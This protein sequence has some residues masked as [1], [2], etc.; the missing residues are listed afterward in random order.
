MLVTFNSPYLTSI[1]ITI[2]LLSEGENL[3]HCDPKAPHVTF[4]GEALLKQ[5]L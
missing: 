1:H 2:W 3:P 5:A 4:G